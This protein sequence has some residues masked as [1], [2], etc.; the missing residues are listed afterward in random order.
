MLLAAY[1][2]DNQIKL[3]LV[4]IDQLNMSQICF[5][6]CLFVTIII[7]ESIQLFPRNVKMFYS[8]NQ[9]QPLPIVNTHPHM[10][11]LL[12]LVMISFLHTKS[13]H[14]YVLSQRCSLRDLDNVSKLELISFIIPLPTVPMFIQK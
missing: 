3:R 7:E 2:R 11:S 8:H 12:K 6:V 5:F 1:S 9:S 10:H 13:P 14:Q 4:D